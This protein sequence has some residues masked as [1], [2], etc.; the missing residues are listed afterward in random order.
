MPRIYTSELIGVRQDVVDEILLLNPYQIPI[1]SA[2]GLGGSND[3]DVAIS[4]KHE[5]F[6]DQLF[7]TKAAV[8]SAAAVTDTQI[9]VANME[10]FRVNL[11]IKHSDNLC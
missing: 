8:T 2:L 6:E 9:A 11:V 3:T 7:D 5:W 1:I 10:P 4:T